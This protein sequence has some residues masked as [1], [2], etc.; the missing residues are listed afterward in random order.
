MCC[1]HLQRKHHSFFAYN[2]QQLGHFE[3]KT[4]LTSSSEFCKRSNFSV[5]DHPLLVS[6]ESAQARVFF[7]EPR[8]FYILQPSSHHSNGW[9]LTRVQLKSSFKKLVLSTGL[10]QYAKVSTTLKAL[11]GLK[12]SKCE[13]GQ[14]SNRLPIPYVAEMDIIMPK[15][16]P[17][18]LKVKHPNDSHLNMPIYSHGNTKENLAHIVAVLH[19]IKQKGLDVKCRKL[20][21]DVVKQSKNLKI[22]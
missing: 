9:V 22:L 8:I 21:K 11:N 12:N 6:A 4:L 2:T 20:G 3:F 17:Q 19:I 16:E 1:L 13:N 7:L 14:L 15:K 10:W 5:P 18:D